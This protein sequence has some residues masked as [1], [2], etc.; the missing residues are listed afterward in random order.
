MGL[1]T[2]GGLSLCLGLKVLVFV[3][4]AV[5]PGITWGPRKGF[6]A[7]KKVSSCRPTPRTMGLQVV[8]LSAS[9]I[10]IMYYKIDY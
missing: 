1:Q 10:I 2:F 9:N 6:T 7:F 5:Y 3:L 4:S 8:G